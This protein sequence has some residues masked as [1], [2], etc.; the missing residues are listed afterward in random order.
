[1]ARWRWERG[2]GGGGGGCGYTLVREWYSTKIYW[3]GNG[4]IYTFFKYFTTGQQ[5]TQTRQL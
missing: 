1:M 2:G 4:H 3:Q 5:G